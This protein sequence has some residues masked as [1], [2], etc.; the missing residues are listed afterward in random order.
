MLTSVV[1][2]IHNSAQ[3][4][5]DAGRRFWR[6]ITPSIPAP[7]N[8][9][10]PPWPVGRAGFLIANPR[11]KVFASPTKQ[12]IGAKPNRE[13]IALSPCDPS[14]HPSA[15][16]FRSE[17]SNRNSRIIRNSPKCRR[18][19]TYAFS[20]RNK[21]AHSGIFAALLLAA[22]GHQMRPASSQQ[23]VRQRPK[24]VRIQKEMAISPQALRT[25]SVAGQDFVDSVNPA[26]GEV[27]ARFPATPLS[28]IPAIFDASRGAQ[29]EW[30]ARTLRERCTML[31]QL[32]DAIFERRD[33]IANIVVRE[34]GKPRAEA[35][36]AEILL[37]LDT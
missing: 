20:N 14:R 31:R 23:S 33:D 16:K 17:I 27:V 22:S 1:H 35:I 15:L 36:L 24:S 19:N 21:T 10:R 7:R 26:T 11:L 8:L 29:K 18:N 4:H 9:L 2:A 25:Q 34:T 3:D 30:S 12:S 37:T 28:A 32:R 13:R 6:P 5:K